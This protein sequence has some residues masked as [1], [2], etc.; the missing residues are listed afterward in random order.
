MLG[1]HAFLVLL[2]E[3]K[4]FGQ[5]LLETPFQDE[6]QVPGCF[7]GNHG[8]VILHSFNSRRAFAPVGRRGEPCA[9][10]LMVKRRPFEH[11]PGGIGPGIHPKAG[12]SFGHLFREVAPLGADERYFGEFFPDHLPS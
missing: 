11:Y 3:L 5:G 4:V 7:A 9:P 1:R 10:Q 2:Q 8:P 12:Q 6:A